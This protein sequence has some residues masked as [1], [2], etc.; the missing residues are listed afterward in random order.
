LTIK[1]QDISSYVKESKLIRSWIWWM[2]TGVISLILQLLVTM[3][4][5]N[6]KLL[7]IVRCKKSSVYTFS[8]SQH[9][10]HDITYFDLSSITCYPLTVGVLNKAPTTDQT[11]GVLINSITITWLY[12]SCDRILNYLRS[13]LLKIKEYINIKK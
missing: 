8:T 13:L 1:K 3:S 7:S 6:L 9:E 11:K 5:S 10:E 4:T 12:L 2:R